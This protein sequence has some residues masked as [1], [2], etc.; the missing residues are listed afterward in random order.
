MSVR[1]KQ[2]WAQLVKALQT[3][4]PNGEPWAELAQR[5]RH[6]AEAIVRGQSPA[7]AQ[8]AED[9]TQALLVKFA[10]PGG[11]APFCTAK[12]PRAYL[13][14]CLMNQI[15]DLARK[16][17]AENRAVRRYVAHRASD[18]QER[19]MQAEAGD[20]AADILQC[21]TDEEQRLLKM[22]FWDD[23]SLA[24]IANALGV[25]Y[26]C[27]GTRMFRLI[28]KLKHRYGGGSTV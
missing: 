14:K 16:Q 8:L 12:E 25:S 2:T 22:R 1:T 11:L 7:W 9:A 17:S 19:A 3:A 23:L 13:V 28:Q 18:D 15:A 24:D 4:P 10:T 21:L 6:R 20:L 26:S 27:A 5:T